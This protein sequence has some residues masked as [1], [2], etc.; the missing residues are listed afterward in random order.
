MYAIELFI[1]YNFRKHFRGQYHKICAAV[2]V[3]EH[4]SVSIGRS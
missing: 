4:T 1:L 2:Q 3:T